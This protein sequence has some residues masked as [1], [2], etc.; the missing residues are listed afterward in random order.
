MRLLACATAAA[1][2]LMTIAVTDAQT[3]G[4]AAP[5]PSRCGAVP[6]APSAPDGTT[7]TAAQI[8]AAIA[9]YDSWR[10][11]VAPILDCRRAEALELRAAAD[12][13]A[14][15]FNAANAI[16]RDTGAA[17]QAAAAAF[18]ARPAASRRR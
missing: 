14:N 3:P 10:V 12:A 2:S 9:Q 13:R 17:F 16:A 8:E 6:Q 4:A 11:Q 5:S 15:E 18:A 7:A 1:A